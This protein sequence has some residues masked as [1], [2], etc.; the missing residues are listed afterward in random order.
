MLIVTIL[1]RKDNSFFAIPT[2][3]YT[4]FRIFVVPNKKVNN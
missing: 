3:L 2:N 1:H 4:E